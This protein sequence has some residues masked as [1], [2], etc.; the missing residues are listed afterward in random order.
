[1]NVMR[2]MY[3]IDKSI[4]HFKS[5]KKRLIVNFIVAYLSPQTKINKEIE[6]LLE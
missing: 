6:N 4:D 3:F 5:T 2:I 1:M